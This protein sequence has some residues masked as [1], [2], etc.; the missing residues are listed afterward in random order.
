MPPLLLPTMPYIPCNA[1]LKSVLELVYWYL[2]QTHIHPSVIIQL[3]S[4]IDLSPDLAPV[5]DLTIFRHLPSSMTS[6]D[7]YAW[8]HI[9]QAY[10]RELASRCKVPGS[11]VCT[12]HHR[13]RFIPSDNANCCFKGNCSV[14]VTLGEN[15]GSE[16]RLFYV[17]SDSEL[18]LCI[19]DKSVVLPFYFRF[20]LVFTFICLH[21]HLKR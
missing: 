21:D 10:Y 9:D 20:A 1:V 13:T 11:C 4:V 3:L 6:G 8:P 12:W 19:A 7:W 14:Q 18:F 17:C 2:T 15:K 16:C 5:G